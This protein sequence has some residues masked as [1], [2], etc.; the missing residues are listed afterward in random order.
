MFYTDKLNFFFLRF[1]YDYFLPT[2][3]IKVFVLFFLVDCPDY[4][5]S[6]FKLGDLL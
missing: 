1:D 2:K 3:L 5:H 4:L 6:A